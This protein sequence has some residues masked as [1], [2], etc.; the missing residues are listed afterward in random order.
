MKEE[1]FWAFVWGV[2]ATVALLLIIVMAFAKGYDAGKREAI[3]APQ[4][5]PAK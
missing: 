5:A 3:R 4:S 2:L 1:T